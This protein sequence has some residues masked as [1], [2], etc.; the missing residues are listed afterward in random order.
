M[1][2]M[3]ASFPARAARRVA[4]LALAAGALAACDADRLAAPIEGSVTPEGAAANPTG[5]LRLLANGILVQNRASQGVW[6]RDAALFGREAFYFQLQDGRWTTGYFRDFEQNTSFG[7]GGVWAGR[8]AN[9]RNIAGLRTTITSVEGQIGAAA[10]SAARGFAS[11]EEALNVQNLV[12]SRF[13]LGTPVRVDSSVNGVTPFVS[14][15]SAYRFV[16]AALDAGFTALQAGG[17]SFPFAFPSSGFAGFTTPAGYAQYNRALKARNE[18]YR[19]SLGCGTACYQ[20][21]L[22][23]LGQSFITSTLTA[24]NLNNGVEYATS[25]ATGDAT[26]ALWA[27]RLDLFANANITTDATVPQTDTRLTS[28][29]QFST[30]AAPIGSR[31]QTG[32]DASNIRFNR[33]ATNSTSLPVIDNEELWLIRAEAQWFTGDRAG[34][35]ATLNTI[36]QVAGGAT[37]NRYTQAANDADFVTQLLAERRLS[38]LLEGHRWVDVRR[39]GRLNTLPTG[40]TGFTVATQQVVPQGECQAR[41]VIIRA[42]GSETLR[43]PGCPPPAQ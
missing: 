23:A 33:Y 14:R 36:A 37:G 17:A 20:A 12:N 19:A 41:D 40:G 34:A 31:S 39:F 42:G 13:N 27:I 6:I 21:A 4:A 3:R 16:S 18:V 43:G 26:N 10:A 11:T 29:L 25:T 30:A 7:S 32:S 35:T 38:L 24:A 2:T 22:T 8:L 1:T 15:D 9:L 5:A 28:K